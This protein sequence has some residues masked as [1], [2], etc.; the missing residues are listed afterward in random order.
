MKQATALC[1]ALCSFF[2]FVCLAEPLTKVQ[3]QQT[4]DYCTSLTIIADVTV[5]Q[6]AMGVPKEA[7]RPD[8]RIKEYCKKQGWDKDAR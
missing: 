5:M 8:M 2:P 1:F 4:I 3:Q 7:V 6:R